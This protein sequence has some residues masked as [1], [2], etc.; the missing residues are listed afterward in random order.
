[1]TT[2]REAL[3]A[4]PEGQVV[5]FNAPKIEHIMAGVA[6]VRISRAGVVHLFYEDDWGECAPASDKILD[7]EVEELRLFDLVSWVQDRR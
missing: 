2:L 5:V 1:M 6:D 4:V 7:T 3:A